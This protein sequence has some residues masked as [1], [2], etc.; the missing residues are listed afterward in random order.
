METQFDA[1]ISYSVLIYLDSEENV[2][3]T[4]MKMDHVVK[5][6]ER[7]I[8]GEI[9][10]IKKNIVNIIRADT[11]FYKNHYVSNVY[12]SYDFSINLARKVEAEIEFIEFNE[13]DLTNSY[14]KA[15][16]RFNVMLKLPKAILSEEVL[17][18]KE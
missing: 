5:S 12:L 2:R 9:N 18:K 10:D 15:S 17:A 13:V 11:H 7:I 6:G 4:I 1:V 16:Y 3:E 8:L 14:P